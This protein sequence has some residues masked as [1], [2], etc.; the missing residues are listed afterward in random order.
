MLV[1]VQE[2]WQK[3]P[4]EAIAY[5]NP[6]TGSALMRYELARAA[7]RV[8]VQLTDLLTGRTVLA[9]ALEPEA[10]PHEQRVDVSRLPAGNYSYRLV[11][12]GLPT[13][14]QHLVIQK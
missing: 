4:L 2:I 9:V 13:A 5:P 8:E 3:A 11:L 10:G 12:D 7:Q 14:P 6:A 1:S